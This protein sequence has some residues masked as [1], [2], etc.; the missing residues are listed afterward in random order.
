MENKFNGNGVVY[1][2]NELHL[3]EVRPA[4]YDFKSFDNIGDY[5]LKY[6]GNFV[7]D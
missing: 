4:S 7:D 6:D 1:N 3:N 5:W 2:E